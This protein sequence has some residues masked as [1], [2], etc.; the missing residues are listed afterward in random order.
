MHIL[1]KLIV[2]RQLFLNEP[3]HTVLKYCN[4]T[5]FYSRL[6]ILLDTVNL[7]KV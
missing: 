4:L 5:Q 3:G 2:F 1:C 6:F 7:F